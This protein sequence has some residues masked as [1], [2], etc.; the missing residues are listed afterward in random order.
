MT[1][2]LFLHTTLDHDMTTIR[3][4]RDLIALLLN[5]HAIHLLDVNLATDIDHAQ[6]QEI[7]TILQDIHLL[8]TTF[9]SPRF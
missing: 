9:E 4:T 7:T 5:P 1:K 8:L 2:V 6:I 3:E